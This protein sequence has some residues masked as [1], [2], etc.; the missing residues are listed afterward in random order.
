MKVQITK[1]ALVQRIN[2]YLAKENKALHQTGRSNRTEEQFGTYYIID[3][4]M[5]CV[6]ADH[7]DLV[8]YGRQI[9]VLKLYEEVV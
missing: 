9:E 7:I 3:T 4:A 1:R 8:E 5:N 6:T 2:R